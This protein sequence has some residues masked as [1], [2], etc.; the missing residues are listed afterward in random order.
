CPEILKPL[1]RLFQ[2]GD[3]FGGT[4]ISYTPVEAPKKPLNRIVRDDSERAAV[5]LIDSTAAQKLSEARRWNADFVAMEIKRLLGAAASRPL[6]DLS[7]KNQPFRP[8]NAGDIAVLVFRHRE[9]R[10]LM[11][12]LRLASIPFSYYKQRNLW[13]SDV[14]DHL[15]YVLRALA[16]PED[17]LSF[18]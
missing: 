15:D 6:M 17:P 9:T 8:L 3:W 5:T 10:P 16:Q 13:Q 12:K 4:E 11:K 1:N 7:L 2:K 18:D 14:V